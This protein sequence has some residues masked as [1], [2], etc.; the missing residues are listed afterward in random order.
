MPHRLWHATLHGEAA[1]PRMFGLV[2]GA[3]TTSTTA[4]DQALDHEPKP[5]QHTAPA[6]RTKSGHQRLRNGLRGNCQNVVDA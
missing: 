5:P 4:R 2:P 6:G 3:A 1:Q